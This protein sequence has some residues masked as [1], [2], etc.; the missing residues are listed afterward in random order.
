MKR[1]IVV[2][3]FALIPLLYFAQESEIMSFTLEEAQNYAIE[4][5][6]KIKNANIDNEIAKNKVW[7]TTAI[8]LPQVSGN[9]KYQ[10][11]FTVPEMSFGGY[12]DWQAMD[13]TIPVTSGYVLSNYVMP[14]PIQMGV[15][16]NVTWD[17]TVSQLVFS[18]EY[19]VGLQAA[20][21]YQQISEMA[22]VKAEIGLKSLISETYVLVKVLQENKI[23]I[24]ESLENTEKL[25]VEMK[26]TNKAGLLDK[27]SVDQFQL[28]VFNLTNAVS[29][30]EKQIQTMK[31]LL[32][33]QM[34]MDIKQ[35]ILLTESVEDILAKVNGEQLL[36]QEFVVN[37][38][39]DYQML[40]VQE[41]VTSLALKRQKS[42]VL[43]TLSAFYRHQEQMK[44]AE[45]NFFSPDMIG[46]TLSIP[47][48]SSGGRYSKI[49]QSKLDLLKLQ[50]TKFDVESALNMQVEQNKNAFI[51]AS[52]KYSLEKQN[53]VLS[54][55]I[56][57]NTL[58]MFQNGTAS[59]LELTQAQ[60]QMLTA[61][62]G[63]YNSL[64]ELLQAKNKL[65]KAL[66]NY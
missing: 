39:I 48:F 57:N 4:N 44:T 24:V 5:S 46:A 52:E 26:A 53:L 17:V 55:T 62:T 25:L 12:I 61:Q 34:G 29:S 7:E 51:T 9:I 22:I 1:Q 14:E 15:K 49:E 41:E 63:C 13:P 6:V 42:T 28:T 36:L 20:K 47:I 21:T 32:K 40:N 58:I 30:I 66:N 38:H 8:G 27:T 35:E 18:G 16:E 19:L 3:I 43:P 54:K 23:I 65:D 64:L 11:T 45:F 56:Y 10:N 60:N 2:I 33:Y 37:N 50:N 59:S 31:L